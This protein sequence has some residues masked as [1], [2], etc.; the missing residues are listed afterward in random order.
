MKRILYFCIPAL[1]FTSSCVDS[2]DDYNINTKAATEVPGATLVTSAERSL[3]NIITSSSV[4]NNPF[5]FYAQYWAAT[6]YPDESQF[7]IATRQIDRNFWDPFYRD[8][9]RDLKEAKTIITAN[10]LLDPKVKANQLA[11]IEVLEVYAWSV[12]VNTFGDVPYSEALD[13]TKVLPKYDDDAA[14]YA[15]LVVRLDKAIGMFDANANGLGT[16]DLIYNGNVP[17]WVAFANSLKLRLG[18]TLADVDP[19]KAKAMVEAAAANVIKSNAQSADITYL[20]ATPNNNPVHSDLILSGRVDF[21]GGNTIID[22]MNAL[23]DPRIN[24]YFKPLEN[25]TFKGGTQGTLNSA[26]TNSAPGAILESPTN[27]GMLLSYA[28]VEF[29]LAEAVER[30]FAVGGTAEAHYNAGITASIT[31][32]GGTEAEAS[33]YI[34]Q[35]GVAYATAAGDFK[36]KIGVQK[37]LALY[38]N[39]VEAWKEWRR[40]DA[41][42][43]VKP[44]TAISEIPLR[45]TYPTTEFNSNGDNANAASAAI[46]GNT[47]TS[48]IF[49]DKN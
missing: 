1:L 7:V 5:R 47:V 27:P 31:E 49:W 48:R 36:Q 13:I 33:A 3:S 42:S 29:L 16:A 22:R 40:L 38:N 23:S 6:T 10:N 37:W 17:N 9:L 24:E 28:E 46:G 21:V 32:W 15:D 39:P 19:A 26:A 45:L 14:I 11:S 25:G 12:L 34:A 20:S 4:N 30:G 43:L 8:V 18:M 44:A 35:P 2:L 41:P